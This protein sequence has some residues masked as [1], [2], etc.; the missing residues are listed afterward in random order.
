MVQGCPQ[1]YTYLE[2]SLEYPRTLSEKT[3]HPNT[4]L[5]LVLHLIKPYLSNFILKLVCVI[6][7]FS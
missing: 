3:K 7:L 1:L 2:V 6:L 4:K 5:T